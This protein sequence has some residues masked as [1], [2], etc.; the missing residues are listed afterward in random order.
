MS[1]ARKSATRFS[2]PIFMRGVSGYN[3]RELT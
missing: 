3:G 1:R 2:W